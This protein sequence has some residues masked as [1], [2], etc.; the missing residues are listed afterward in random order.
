MTVPIGFRSTRFE[1]VPKGVPPLSATNAFDGVKWIWMNGRQVEFDKA[2]V[3]V[4]SHGLHYGSGVFEGIRCYRTPEGPAIFRL[5][6][7]LER[8]ENSF[9]IYR[10]EIP[11]SRK[12]L[13]EATCEI[14]QANG[15]DECYIRPLAFRGLGTLGVYPLNCPIDVTIAVWPWGSYLGEDGIR[16][17]VDVCVS[18]WRRAAPG[19]IPTLSKATGNYLSSQLMKMEAMANGYAEG[20]ALD[21]EGLVS[22]GSGENLFAVVNGVLVTPPLTASI[23]PGI[24]RRTVVRLAADLGIDV[25]RERMP[26]EMLYTCDELFFCGTAAEVTPIRSV[27]RIPVGDGRPGPVTARIR[28]EYLGVVTGRIEDRHGWLT[29]VRAES[30]MPV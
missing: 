2:Q 16:N 17:G 1:A 20:I 3:H 29:R 28:D 30:A 27:D 22:E 5:E 21:V 23:L 26:R 12:E 10:G 6:E 7:H 9:K 18:S 8:F 13:T 25:V 24:T 11:Y 14:I 19:T 15:F 4:L